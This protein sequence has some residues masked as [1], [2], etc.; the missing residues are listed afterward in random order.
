MTLVALAFAMLFRREKHL[1]QNQ[2]DTFDR[3]DELRESLKA[4]EKPDPVE[5]DDDGA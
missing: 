1:R 2:W 3:W 4:Q 5:S